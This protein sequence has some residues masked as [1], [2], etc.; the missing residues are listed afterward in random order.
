[1][2]NEFNELDQVIEQLQQHLSSSKIEF[3]DY[4]LPLP[5]VECR[6]GVKFSVQA[7]RHHYSTPRDNLG[8]WTT[9][10]VMMLTP[11]VEPRNW[12]VDEGDDVSSY[13][14]IEAVAQE[15]LDRGFLALTE[16]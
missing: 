11:G 6:D 14:P 12:R 7:G 16:E 2:S 10:E 4:K 3:G 13:V 5:P 1:M 8:P 9:V 15:I